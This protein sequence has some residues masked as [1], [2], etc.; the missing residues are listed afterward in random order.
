MDFCNFTHS[1]IKNLQS[2]I[3]DIELWCTLWRVKLNPGKSQL[4]HFKAYGKQGMPGDIY[5]FNQKLTLSNTAKF[6]GITFDS[7]LS[8]NDHF[9]DITRRALSRLNA[10]KS[11]ICNRKTNSKLLLICIRHLSDPSLNMAVSALLI[12]QN[13]T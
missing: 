6:L 3:S 5:L 9:N 8:F 1:I 4:I 10:L 12:Q 7:H 2:A 13:R 11:V